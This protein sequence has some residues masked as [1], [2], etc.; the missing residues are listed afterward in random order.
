VAL[1]AARGPESELGGV[2]LGELERLGTGVDRLTELLRLAAPIAAAPAA[3]AEP[4]AP[5]AEE[6]SEEAPS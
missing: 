4:D 3:P 5:A 1:L 2:V 6:P